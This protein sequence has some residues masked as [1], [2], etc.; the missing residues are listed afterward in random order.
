MLGGR[1]HREC[2]DAEEGEE[3]AARTNPEPLAGRAIYR[4]RL[5]QGASEVN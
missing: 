4:G 3:E 1:R 5:D 2:G